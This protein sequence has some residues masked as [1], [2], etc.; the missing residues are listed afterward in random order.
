[1]AVR[2]APSA[3][4]HG[5]DVARATHVIDNCADPVY[6]GPS[7]PGEPDR[8]LFLGPDQRGVPLEVVALELSPGELLVIHA[9]KL[10]R[11]YWDDYMRVMLWHVRS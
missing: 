8:V 2:F 5:I 3:W 7:T 10:R 9:M 1:M 6:P 4:R 11:N